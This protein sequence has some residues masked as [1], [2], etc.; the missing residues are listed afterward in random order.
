MRKN[1]SQTGEAG[2]A[3]NGLIISAPTGATDYLKLAQ[4]LGTGTNHWLNSEPQPEIH[5]DKTVAPLCTKANSQL[6][7]CAAQVHITYVIIEQVNQ[8]QRIFDFCKT[9]VNHIFRSFPYS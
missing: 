5:I 9:T 2:R 4:T 8:A 6:Y 1:S 7:F 3:L